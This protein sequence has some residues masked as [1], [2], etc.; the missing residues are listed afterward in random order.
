M[1]SL[2]KARVLGN[3]KRKERGEVGMRKA[4]RRDGGKQR[5]REGRKD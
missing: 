3:E 1:T 4:R 5:N 2:E